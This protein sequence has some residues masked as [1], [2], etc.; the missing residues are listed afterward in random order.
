MRGGTSY[1]IAQGVLL[2]IRKK[3]NLVAFD[4]FLCL[5]VGLVGVVQGVLQLVDV[6][7]KL[8]LHPEH[9]MLMKFRNL[10]LQMV[11]YSDMAAL[12]KAL[13]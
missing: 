6:S 10:A 3:L 2:H 5:A 12:N 9:H 8:L 13:S 1:A 4:G 7:L 11:S